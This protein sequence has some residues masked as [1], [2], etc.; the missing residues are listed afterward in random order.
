MKH[1]L[2]PTPKP[3]ELV[4]KNRLK[5]GESIILNYNKGIL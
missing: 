3:N 4:E 2:P 5:H 1:H